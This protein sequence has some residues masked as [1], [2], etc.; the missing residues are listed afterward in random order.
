MA[1]YAILS[2]LTRISI[3]YRP[4]GRLGADELADE[5]GSLFL[6]MLTGGRG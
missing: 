1:T 4:G 2:G 5:Y 6:T 3:W